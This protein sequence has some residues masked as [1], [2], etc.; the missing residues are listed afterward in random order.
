MNLTFRP[1]ALPDFDEFFR[2]CFA[3]DQF[4]I[5]LRAAVEREWVVLLRNPTT[6]SMIVEDRERPVGGRLVG[7]A[8]SVFITEHFAQ[9]ARSGLPPWINVQATHA[10]PD[11]SWPL[12]GPAGVRAANSGEGL[13]GL[14]TRWN[15]ARQNMRD[16]DIIYL[17]DYLH[18]SFATFTRGYKFKELLVEATGER[19]MQEAVRSGFRLLNDHSEHYPR[20]APVPAPHARPYLLHLTREAAVAD[21]GCLVSYAFAY[22]PPRCFFNEREQ[23]L[24]RL[25]LSGAED[26]EVATLLDRTIWTIRKRWQ[27]IYERVENKAPALLPPPTLDRKRGTEKRRVLLR[28][29]QEHPEELRPH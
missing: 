26:E 16:A 6:L 7:C 3:N 29:L 8:Q 4:N 15:I 14:I 18:R 9:L 27:S 23:E 13:V 28:Y 20:H 21:E 19:A 12:L 2:A 22:T 10:L 25:A 11:G 17:R 24:L 1:A 5:E